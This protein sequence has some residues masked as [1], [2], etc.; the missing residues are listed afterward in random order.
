MTVDCSRLDYISSAGLRILLIMQKQCGRG[1]TVMNINETVKE[2]LEQ[3][4]FDSILNV[5][6]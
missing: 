6:K 3:T 1:V 5:E 2:I 4:G